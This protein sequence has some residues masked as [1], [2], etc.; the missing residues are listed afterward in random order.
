MTAGLT[1]PLFRVEPGDLLARAIEEHRPVAT[2]AMISGGNDST[3][4][5]LATVEHV[6]ITAAVFIDTGTS[7]PGV[8]DHARHVAEKVGVPFRAYRAPEGEFERMVREHGFPGPAQHRMAYVRL[9][10]RA[11]DRLI[12]ETKTHRLDRV[13]LTS[14]VRRQE[15][16]RRM[17]TAVELRRDGATV[18][19]APIIDWTKAECRA[20]RERAGIGQSDVAALIHRSGECNC[21]AYA[22][23]DERE[24]LATFFP[25]WDRRI[26]R[27]ER[28]AEALGV[29][30]RW[31]ERPKTPDPTAAELRARIA[32]PLNWAADDGEELEADEIAEIEQRLAMSDDELVQEWRATQ[33]RIEARSAGPMCVGCEGQLTLD[34]GLS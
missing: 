34:G 20:A 24:M 8:E 16:I 17:G 10:E 25:E 30:C 29:P 2:F 11:L 21:G 28:E 5:L 19:A 22:A 18:W 6:E 3:A 33:A 31:G 15:S 32:A 13:L 1:H 14:G 12:A 27:L 23:P 4:A 7:L 26:C 9:K